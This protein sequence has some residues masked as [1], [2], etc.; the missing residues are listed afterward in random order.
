MPA[1]LGLA[2]IVLLAAVLA[3]LSMSAIAPPRGVIGLAD[4]PPVRAA[5]VAALGWVGLIA[6]MVIALGAALLL[7][8]LFKNGFH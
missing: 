3:W 4:P 1:I 2:G 8:F 5:W 7:A 6:A